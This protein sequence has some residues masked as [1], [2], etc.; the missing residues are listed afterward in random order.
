MLSEQPIDAMLPA[1]DLETANDSYANK[2]G[3]EVLLDTDAFVAFRCG[4]DSRLVVTTSGADTRDADE[5]QLARV[6]DLAS[7]GKRAAR[8]R[9]RA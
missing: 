7:A 9:S 3:S 4:G 1:T 8:P 2:V 5:G 6:D